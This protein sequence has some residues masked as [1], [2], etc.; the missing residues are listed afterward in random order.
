MGRYRVR[1]RWRTDYTLYDKNRDK[2]VIETGIL[3]IQPEDC[4]KLTEVVEQW[5]T[6]TNNVKR[7]CSTLIVKKIQDVFVDKFVQMAVIGV[8]GQKTDV[9][10]VVITDGV[11]VIG[12]AAFSDCEHLKFLVLPDSVKVISRIAF[13]R[14]RNLTSLSLPH[15]LTTVDK[16]A[17]AGCIKLKTVRFRPPV[18]RAKAVFIVWAVGRARNRANFRVTTLKN[19]RNVLCL[20]TVFALEC[21]APCSIG[22][23]QALAMKFAGCTKLISKL[24]IRPDDTISTAFLNAKVVQRKGIDLTVQ[25]RQL[26]ST[27]NVI[28]LTQT[29]E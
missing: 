14:C 20:I 21:R 6:D 1:Y 22:K 27:S 2:T 23:P 7:V 13:L 12:P 4:N 25:A 5:P 28:D 16:Y 19:L 29:D 17:F 9:T 11:T 8:R 24:K 10:K 15:G 18:G 3:E 26:N